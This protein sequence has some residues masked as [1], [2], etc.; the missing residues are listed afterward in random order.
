MKLIYYLNSQILN[1][2]MKKLILYII[3]VATIS[4]K[5]TQKVTSVDQSNPAEVAKAVLNYY[6]NKDLESLR[7]LSTNQKSL[8][9][10]RIILTENETAQQKI[11]NGWRWEKINE[12]NGEI[13][14]VR[15]AD[16][17][18]SAYALFNLPKNAEPTSPAVV[19]TMMSENKKWKFDDIQKYTKQSFEG[20]GYVME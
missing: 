6:K 5:S 3:I 9:I 10:Q 14:E 2:T 1:T 17:L 8:I 20:L 13:V 12:W 7:Y 4:C 19:V 11:F 16:N 15:F 18:K